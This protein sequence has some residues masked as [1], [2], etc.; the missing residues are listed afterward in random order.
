MRADLRAYRTQ[1]AQL[2]DQLLAVGGVGVVR[3]V[4]AEVVVE[5]MERALGSGGVDVDFNRLGLRQRGG[6]KADCTEAGQACKRFQSIRSISQLVGRTPWSAR[7]A[8]VPLHE[9]EHPAE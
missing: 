1:R 6:A 2:G 7:D 3:L 5:G 4:I 9:W 8:L